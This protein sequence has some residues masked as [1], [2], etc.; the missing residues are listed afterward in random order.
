MAMEDCPAVAFGRWGLH[1]KKCV[2]LRLGEKRIEE[3]ERLQPVSPTGE[4]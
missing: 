1:A 4:V 2:P 3:G